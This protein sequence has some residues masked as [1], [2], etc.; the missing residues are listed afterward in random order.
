M[1]GFTKS[2][3]I[4]VAAL[5]VGMV[6]VVGL[7]GCGNII[8]KTTSRAKLGMMPAGQ[9]LEQMRSDVKSWEDA[10]WALG[11]LSED[12]KRMAEKY[13][14]DLAT[15]NEDIEKQITKANTPADALREM[16]EDVSSYVITEFPRHSRALGIDEYR[17]NVAMGDLINKG[18]DA[19]LH[20][21][22]AMIKDNLYKN[23]AFSNDF[24]LLAASK[25][26]KAELINALNGGDISIFTNPTGEPIGI[27]DPKYTYIIEGESWLARE[28]T[29]DE[30]LV[31]RTRI[32]SWHLEEQDYAGSII[33]ERS[34]FYH[35]IDEAFITEAEND[36]RAALQEK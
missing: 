16:V 27:V 36:R 21:A 13:A 33:I 8:P 14:A 35:P 30:K 24:K 2:K 1:I 26:R 22:L 19:R 23:E 3:K 15:L 12:L 7:G 29:F 11:W 20:G 31:V 10:G 18:N 34:Y 28:G 25:S 17:L 5:C 4:I 6:A 32:Q 9:A